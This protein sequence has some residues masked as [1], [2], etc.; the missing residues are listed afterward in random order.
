MSMTT[1]MTA[2]ELAELEDDGSRHELIAGSLLRLPLATPYQSWV[3][4]NFARHL[5]EFVEPKELGIV[6][7]SSAGYL[8]EE[9]PDTVLAPDGT[10]ISRVRFSNEVNWEE[11]F[12]IVP[13]VL[14]EIHSPSE[15][16]YQFERKLAIYLTK[17]VHLV[18]YADAVKRQ[19]T[20]YAP[21]RE[22]RILTENDVLTF[23]DIV[24]G[25]RL[26]VADLFALPAWLQPPTNGTSS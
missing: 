26:P 8:F 4:L 19:L 24:P 25:F 14:L 7:G 16:Q 1:L 15:Q 13:N 18:I 3:S 20:L 5:R 17:G 10:F 11:Y 6:L 23:E 9:T 22:P 21:D 12:R 2:L